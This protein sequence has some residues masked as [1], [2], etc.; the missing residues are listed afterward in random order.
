MAQT[1]ADR[2]A[3]AKKAAATDSRSFAPRPGAR[4]PNACIP[5][6]HAFGPREVNARSSKPAS[7]NHRRMLGVMRL[8]RCS[9]R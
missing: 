2:F 3:A 9:V 5:T 8:F 1:K 4:G 7:A 6:D